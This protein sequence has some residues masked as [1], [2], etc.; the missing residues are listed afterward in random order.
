LLTPGA[1]VDDPDSIEILQRF[2]IDGIEIDP[3]ADPRPPTVEAVR[4]TTLASRLAAIYGSVDKVDAFVGMVAE[5]HVRGSELG[6]LQRAI[7]A[8]QFRALRDGD[9]FFYG[10]DPGLTTIERRYGI[11]FRH[12]LA[13]VIAANTD[14]PLDDLNANVFVVAEEEPAPA[15]TPTG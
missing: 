9:R 2:D 7:W 13:E 11:D 3:E 1:E 6:E 14:I 10:N 5:P 12:T 15:P 4:R 8:Q